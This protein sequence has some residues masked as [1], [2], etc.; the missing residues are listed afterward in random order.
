MG[1]GGDP[2]DALG[3]TDV[4][5]RTAAARELATSGTPADLELLLGLAQTDKSPSVRLY[6]AAA[7]SEIATREVLD[8]ERRQQVLD[9]LRAWDPG[10][11][12]SLVLVFAGIADAAGIKRLGLLLRDPRRDVRTAAATAVRRMASLPQAPKILAGEVGGWL[13]SGK[14][15]A[16]AAAELIRLAG[17]QGWVAQQEAIRAGAKAGRAAA[18]AADQALEW[19]AARQD[20]TSWDGTW[21]TTDDGE[22]EWL[23]ILERQGFGRE[24]ALGELEVVD[25]VG[26]LRGRPPLGRA[27]ATRTAAEGTSE[28]ITME[29]RLL[30]RHRANALTRV[31]EELGTQ[32]RGVPEV[33]HGLA[34]EMK[35]LEGV[36]AVR[37]RAFALWM[38]GQLAEADRV[39]QGIFASEKRH[40]PHALWVRANVSAQLGDLD[41]ARESVEACLASAPKRAAYRAD[42]EA[43]LASLGSGTRTVNV[44]P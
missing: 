37:A 43:L 21:M 30:W 36:A 31:V 11:N 7:A 27:W 5:E 10:T 8:Q 35:D 17:E 24:G 16:D 19:L 9:A 41:T 12:P 40:H 18:E 39:L 42:A 2:R 29:G 28:A 25:G 32:L 14:Y 26:T 20:P 4:A 38:S 15:P 33:A 1:E 23:Y 6:A 34:A 3:S 13:R 44:E 22:T